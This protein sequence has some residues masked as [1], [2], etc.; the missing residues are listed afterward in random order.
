MLIG[1]LEFYAFKKILFEY[2]VGEWYRNC[3]Q[4]LYFSF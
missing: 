3:V 2:G 1:L 4:I